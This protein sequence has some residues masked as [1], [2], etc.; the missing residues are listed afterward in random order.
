MLEGEA[1]VLANLCGALEAMELQ[2]RKLRAE[3][4]SGTQRKS[5]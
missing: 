5:E 1:L 4:G 2:L 3:N